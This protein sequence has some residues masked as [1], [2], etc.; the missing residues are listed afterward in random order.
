MMWTKFTQDRAGK[1]KSKAESK[2]MYMLLRRLLNSRKGID[3]GNRE[4]ESIPHFIRHRVKMLRCNSLHW[5]ERKREK[6]TEMEKE[7]ER[8]RDGERDR[9]RDRD[10]EREKEKERERG[11]KSER[12]RERE[13]TPD[14][15]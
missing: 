3:D 15:N 6:E 4:R 8:E 9:E 5:G 12:E 10:R 11:R 2:G 13:K 14:R 7:R 1:A